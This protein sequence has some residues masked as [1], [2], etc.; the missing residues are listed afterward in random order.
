MGSHTTF[1]PERGGLPA[2]RLIRVAN[3]PIID[4]GDPNAPNSFDVNLGCH[5]DPAGWLLELAQQATR[6]AAEYQHSLRMAARAE[7]RKV[8]P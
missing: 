6:L 4:I 2:G 1:F 5:P 3:I 7:S 8:A